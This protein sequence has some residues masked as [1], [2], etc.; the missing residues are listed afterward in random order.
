LNDEAVRD[1]VDAYRAK[2]SQKVL[3]LPDPR[4]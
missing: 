4:D 2:Q 3:D 1:A